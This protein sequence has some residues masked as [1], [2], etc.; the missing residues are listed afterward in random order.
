MNLKI[1]FKVASIPPPF[2]GNFDLKLTE[3]CACV[4]RILIK[5]Q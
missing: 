3:A 4:L 1:N 2:L 5:F